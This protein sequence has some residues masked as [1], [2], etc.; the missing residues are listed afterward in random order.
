[1]NGLYNIRKER[2]SLYTHYKT[3]A[4]L[5]AKEQ[6]EIE[7]AGLAIA[8]RKQ[9]ERFLDDGGFPKHNEVLGEIFGEYAI[10][11]F[12]SDRTMC[13][14]VGDLDAFSP[15]FLRML[16]ERVL[17]HF[18]LW[19]LVAQFEE[20]SVGVYPNGVW[21]GSEWV[22]G[23]WDE[24][25]P[26]FQ[27][28]LRKASTY[29]EKRFG[30]LRRQLTFVE[31]LLPA[32]L[33]RARRKGICLLACFDCYQPHL[34]GHAVWLL[35]PGN[36][37]RPSLDKKIGGLRNSAVSARGKILPEFD[38]RFEPYSD[39]NPP[40]WVDTYSLS[41]ATQHVI[42]IKNDQDEVVE[43]II[44]RRIVRDKMLQREELRRRSL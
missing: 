9:I 1:M 42:D 37:K 12:P 2:G 30:P 39:R 38:Q 36:R 10:G 22:E 18:P 25:H 4:R 27:S 14:F 35:R 20:M 44:V 32:A 24:T 16:Q 33:D 40:F 43:K 31:K 15:A 6:Y 13:F 41:P 3:V 19:R 23:A 34:R 17:R 28:W 11:E 21:L 5:P 26:A 7:C 8:L 29:R